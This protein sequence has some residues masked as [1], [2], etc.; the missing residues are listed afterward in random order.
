MKSREKVDRSILV[1]E[2]KGKQR[3]EKWDTDWRRTK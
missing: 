3:Q 2:G 1:K